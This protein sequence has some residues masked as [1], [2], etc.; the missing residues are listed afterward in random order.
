MLL[1]FRT[2]FYYRKDYNSTSIDVSISELLFNNK[3]DE[4]MRINYQIRNYCGKNY[5]FGYW[6]VVRIIT[7]SIF[8]P[9]FLEL[10]AYTTYKLLTESNEDVNAFY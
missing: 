9:S 5:I 6:Q 8:L 10:I 4:I 2:G 7:I 1:I 3:I